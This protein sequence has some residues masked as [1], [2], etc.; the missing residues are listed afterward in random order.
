MPDGPLPVG[1]GVGPDYADMPPAAIN[2]P[3]IFT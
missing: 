1:G 2:Y 3:G